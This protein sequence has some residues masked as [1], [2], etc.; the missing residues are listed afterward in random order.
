MAD[1]ALRPLTQEE[2]KLLR[3][4]LEHGSDDA[5]LYL[6]QIEGLRAKRSC[7]CGCP[8]IELVVSDGAPGAVA[9]K[10]RIVADLSGQTPEG[11]SVGV[12]LF[13]DEGKLSELEIYPYENEGE[14]SLP[15]IESLAPFETGKPVS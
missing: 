5:K 12:L 6:P 14:F 11:I 3:W 13:Q 8:S 15:T 7:T 10:E 4:T 2:E 9:A 1:L